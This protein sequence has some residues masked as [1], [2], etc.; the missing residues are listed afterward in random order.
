[1]LNLE[2]EDLLFAREAVRSG[3]AASTRKAAGL[4][5]REVADAVGVTGTAVS[6]WESGK[7]TPRGAVGRAYGRLLRELE[8]RV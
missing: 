4:S 2:L 1:M 7:R 5:Q 6:L 8:R 3:R